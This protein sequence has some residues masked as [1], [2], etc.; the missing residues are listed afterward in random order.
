MFVPQSPPTLVWKEAT[1]GAPWSH[2]SDLCA[3][4][5]GG[6]IVLTGGHADSNYTS[7]V[8]TSED[9]ETWELVL[10]EAPWAA[11]SYHSCAVLP[12]DRMLIVGGH[13]QNEWYNDVWVS[14]PQGNVSHWEQQ[15]PHAA[16]APRAAGSLFYQEGTKT[17]YYLGGSDGLLPPAGKPGA[18][19]L[20]NDVW[21]SKDEGK[22]WSIATPAA[23]WPAR[24]GESGG[25]GV[26]I[27]DDEELALMGGEA[28]YFPDSFFSDVWTSREGLNWTMR[29]EKA[30]WT[31]GGLWNKKGRSG[32]IVAKQTTPGGDVLWLA[33]GYLG[34]HDV[35][36][37]GNVKTAA[38]L[39]R[40]WTLVG[41][42]PWKGRYDFGL[43]VIGGDQ[44]VMFGGE[45]SALG[46]GGPYYNDVWIAQLPAS[47]CQ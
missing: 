22:T 43:T 18:T 21:L 46:F 5:L 36:C 2:R 32:H 37:I 6:R 34:K 16:F 30:E 28:G 33:G 7:D 15:T 38:D 42:A 8:W 44:L 13:S 23:P 35:W 14:G 11:R 24:E 27:G 31:D 4:V 39:A 19:T 26:V 29:A 20:F 12:G 41:E 47:G 45:N 25:S 10:E 1:S 3:A 17:L 9:G 40:P